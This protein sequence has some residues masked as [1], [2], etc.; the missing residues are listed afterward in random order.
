MVKEI[1]LNRIINDFLDKLEFVNYPDNPS[2]E[3]YSCSFLSIHP[4]NKLCYMYTNFIHMYMTN[5]NV[6]LSEK[7][8]SE[9]II[10]RFNLQDYKINVR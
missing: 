9:I 7:I 1:K 3:I 5:L 8:L 6:Y 2:Y 10:K 4:S